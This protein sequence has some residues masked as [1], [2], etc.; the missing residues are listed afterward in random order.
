[1]LRIICKSNIDNGEIMQN[2]QIISLKGGWM[3]YH[4][5]RM[6]MARV[7]W[8]FWTN[9][10]C[11]GKKYHKTCEWQS[12]SIHCAIRLSSYTPTMRWTFAP[13]LILDLIFCMEMG[14]FSRNCAKTDWV[15]NLFFIHQCNQYFLFIV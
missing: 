8:R 3:C 5:I 6:A 9:C 14:Q 4:A 1:M 11:F 15:S 7:C 12:L 2:R 13:V 10:G